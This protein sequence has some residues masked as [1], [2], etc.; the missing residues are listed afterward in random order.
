MIGGEGKGQRESG[1]GPKDDISLARQALDDPNWP[2]HALRQLDGGG[3]YSAWPEQAGYA[4]RNKDR[5]LKK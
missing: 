3:D 2:L 1:A 5:A 4:I